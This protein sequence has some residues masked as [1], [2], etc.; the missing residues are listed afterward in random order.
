MCVY[1]HI[2]TLTWPTAL[3]LFLSI[4]VFCLFTHAFKNDQQSKSR[5][6][7]EAEERLGYMTIS[8]SCPTTHLNFVR[9]TKQVSRKQ[10]PHCITT[11]NSACYQHQIQ[12][13]ATLPIFIMR[14]YSHQCRGSLKQKCNPTVTVRR[15]ITRPPRVKCR[16]KA[17][18]ISFACQELK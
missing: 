3:H 17:P 10:A 8:T 6:G 16:N 14:P 9:R 13:Q 2:W 1:V 12:Q 4:F 11:I 15:L 18:K 7:D 5:P